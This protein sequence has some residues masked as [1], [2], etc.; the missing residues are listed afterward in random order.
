MYHL[1]FICLLDEEEGKKCEDD[2]QSN[3]PLK[4]RH[5]TCAR[6]RNHGLIFNLKGHKRV[7]QYR[8]CPCRRCSLVVQRRQVMA[9]QLAMNREQ[10]KEQ[11]QQKMLEHFEDLPES[12]R[13]CHDWDI[14]DQADLNQSPTKK[15]ADSPEVTQGNLL[16]GNY[17]ATG[18][19][20]GEN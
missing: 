11:H 3:L 18:R 5:P 4:K 14:T 6:C 8:S 19:L 16:S 15:S 12:Q 2:F 7:C 17:W 1:Y 9:R 20:M 10:E 13:F